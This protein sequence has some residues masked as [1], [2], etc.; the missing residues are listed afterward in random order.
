LVR[1]TCEAL[2]VPFEP[3]PVRTGEGTGHLVPTS[4]FL[5]S[6]VLVRPTGSAIAALVLG[7]IHFGSAR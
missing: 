2:R 4:I 7:A 6:T 5:A 3:D 1:Q